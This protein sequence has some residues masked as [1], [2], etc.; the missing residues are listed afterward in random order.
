MCNKR[1]SQDSAGRRAVVGRVVRT[2]QWG[3]GAAVVGCGSGHGPE[4]AMGDHAMGRHGM[5]WHEIMMGWHEVSWAVKTWIDDGTE[6][7]EGIC[8]L[9]V[10]RSL[11]VFTTVEKRGNKSFFSIM[12]RFCCRLIAVHFTRLLMPLFL[13][14]TC[15]LMPPASI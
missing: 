8:K 1:S 12:S 6:V 9:G 7:F 10:W 5:A 13:P 3:A 11:S 4:R 2:R 15:L 14:S